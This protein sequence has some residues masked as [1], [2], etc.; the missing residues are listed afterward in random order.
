[1]DFYCVGGCGDRVRNGGEWCPHCWPADADGPAVRM[2]PEIKLSTETEC[3][4]QSYRLACGNKAERA[5]ALERLAFLVTVLQQEQ[6]KE[7]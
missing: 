3:I 5:S 6:Q 1:M 4:Q 7:T 2:A